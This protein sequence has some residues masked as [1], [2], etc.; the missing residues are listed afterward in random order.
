MRKLDSKFLITCAV[1]ISLPIIFIIIMML[2]RGCS[3]AKTYTKYESMMVSRAKTYAKNHKMLPKNGKSTIIKL[4]NLIEDGMKSPDKS[5]KDSSCSGSVVI[6]N[7]SNNITEKKYY[8][9]IPYLE[10]DDYKTEYIRDY[11]LKDVVTSNSGLYKID[12]EYVFKG[13][14]VNNYVSFYGIIYRIIKID[15]D[16]NMKLIK[17]RVQ[18]VSSNWDG[19]YNIDLKAYEGV[20]NYRDSVMIDR[21]VSDYKNDKNFPKDSRG[22]LV[23]HSVCIGKRASTDLSI[24]VTTECDDKIDN[25]VISLI[26]ITDFTHASYDVNCKQLGDLSCTNYNYMAD[27]MDYTWTVDTLSDDSSKVYAIGSIGPELNSA[28]KYEKYNLVIYLNSEELYQGGKGTLNDP[29]IIK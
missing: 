28:V 3:S 5:L 23:P 4:D 6:K 26:S 2:I 16:N 22:K 9:Y 7:Y 18:D 27:F 8:S 19:K 20:N 15:A 12:D 1:I 14:K 17:E 11:L 13:N 24:D 10:C 25:Q 21:L 29:Y